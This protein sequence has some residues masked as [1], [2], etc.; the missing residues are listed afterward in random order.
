VHTCEDAN[1]PW[2]ND[3]THRAVLPGFG[4]G[5]L[6][7]RWMG[8]VD[9]ALPDETHSSP[10]AP[11]L[12]MAFEGGAGLTGAVL[13]AVG[14]DTLVVAEPGKGPDGEPGLWLTPYQMGDDGRLT[15]GEKCFHRSM[16]EKGRS[17]T[18]SPPAG[19]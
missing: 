4:P 5:P 9:A 6:G 10:F 12:A 13:V 7:Y 16:S 17:S 19:E 2:T 18:G 8:L 15:P 11:S 3:W 14:S 1:A